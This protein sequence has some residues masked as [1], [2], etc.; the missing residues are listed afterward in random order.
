VHVVFSHKPDVRSD[1][2]E[3]K[4]NREKACG[5]NSGDDEVRRPAGEF[6]LLVVGEAGEM[7]RDETIV[8]ANVSQLEALPLVFSAQ[9]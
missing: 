3:G 2:E 6:V 1:H 4:C 7:D 9:L 5:A 8:R